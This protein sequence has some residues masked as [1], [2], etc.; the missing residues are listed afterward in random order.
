MRDNKLKKKYIFVEQYDWNG[1][2]IKRYKLDDWGYFCVDE[3]NSKIYL[4]STV[5]PYSLI[6]YNLN[7]TINSID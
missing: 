2:P 3:N 1:N 6:M 7:D 4:V 5:K